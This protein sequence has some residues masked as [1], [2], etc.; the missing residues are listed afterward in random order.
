MSNF[1]ALMFSLK[2]STNRAQFWVGFIGLTLFVM[3]GNAVLRAMDDTTLLAF[4]TSL[5]VFFMAI[6]IIYAVYGK[7]F[8]DLGR[9][10]WMV[11]GMLTLQVLMI[12]FAMLMFGGAEY[13]SE[14]AQ[15]DRKAAIDP[16]VSAAINDKYQAGLEA[17]MS[18]IKAL[19]LIIPVLFTIY[20]GLIPGRSEK[21]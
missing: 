5:F 14:Y 19:F 17:S 11:T 10:P 15:Y 12:I 8:K 21:G 6:Y 1:L 16:E 2:G 13:F 18:K 3:G 4:L 7:R 20:A 9:T